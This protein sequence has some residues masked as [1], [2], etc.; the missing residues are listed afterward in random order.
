VKEY[1]SNNT[2]PNPGQAKNIETSY[3]IEDIINAENKFWKGLPMGKVVEHF[4]VLT[5]RNS[6]NGHPF[7]TNKQLISFYMRGFLKDTSQ[8]TQKINCA[9]GEKGFVIKLFYNFFE[10]AVTNYG[11]PQ[12]KKNFIYLFTDCFSNWPQNTVEAYFKPN[13]TKQQW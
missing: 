11:H 5:K 9:N 6:K 4:E 1:I 13:K 8:P 10:L 3:T 2:I 7:L 12:Q